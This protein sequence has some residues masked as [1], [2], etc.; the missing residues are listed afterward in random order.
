MQP[1][2]FLASI[3]RH[4]AELASQPDPQ[5][6]FVKTQFQSVVEA[7]TTANQAMQVFLKT[8]QPTVAVSNPQTSVR[9]PDVAEVTKAVK[10]LEKA[11]KPLKSDNSDV[12]KAINIMAGRQLKASDIKPPVVNLPA[13]QVK[14]DAPVVK[15]DAPDLSPIT[16]AIKDNKP[17]PIDNSDI[18]KGLKDVSQQIIK[19]PTPV[20][21]T[22]T[23]PLI[24]YAEADIDDVDVSNALKTIRYYGYTNTSGAWYIR[25]LDATNIGTT[26][27]T[28]R[29]SQGISGYSAAWTNRTSLTYVVWGS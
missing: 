6:E 10:A 16:K 15:V 27:K 12:V 26:G 1:S 13:P 23:D 29:I 2:D 4:Q 18:I 21:N 14:V 3:E 19:K 8:Y 7:M 24:Q 25:R 20:A 22:P 9:T 5:K 11:L 28:V 17:Q